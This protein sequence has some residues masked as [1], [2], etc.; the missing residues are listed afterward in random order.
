MGEGGLTEAGMAKVQVVIA[1]LA[2][3]QRRIPDSMQLKLPLARICNSL[4][5]LEE[6]FRTPKGQLSVDLCHGDSVAEDGTRNSRLGLPIDSN[7]AESAA[8][9]FDRSARRRPTTM[10]RRPS[11]RMRWSL[12]SVTQVSNAV[13]RGPANG[14]RSR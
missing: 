3:G 1:Y 11:G 6:V 13:Y 12:I 8:F 2:H 4:R 10:N 5:S 14:N 9:R 7:Y